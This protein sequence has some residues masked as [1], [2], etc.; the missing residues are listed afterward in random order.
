MFYFAKCS[1]CSYERRIDDI[2][3]S[4]SISDKAHLTIRQRCAFCKQCSQVVRAEY[5][6]TTEVIETELAEAKTLNAEEWIPDLLSYLDWRKTRVSPPRCLE[7]GST[8]II[9]SEI[10]ERDDDDD[11][12]RIKHPDCGGTIT[13]SPRGFS[14]N[15]LWIFYCKIVE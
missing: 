9:L 11:I 10:D 2:L 3:R 15:R 1:R 13:I 6:P 12:E 14:L 5:I 4:Y 8:E 7:C